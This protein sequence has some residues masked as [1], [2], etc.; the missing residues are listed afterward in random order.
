MK[1]DKKAVVLTLPEG[2]SDIIIFDDVL[3]GF[4]LRIRRAASGLVRRQWVC[5]YRNRRLLLGSAEVLSVEQAR[6]AAKKALATVA[7]GGDPQAEKADR[8]NQDQHTYRA[9]ADDYLAAKKVK[10]RPRT[11]VEAERY[12]T[13]DR[14]FGPLHS[15]PIDRVQRRDIA[16]RLETIERE[17]GTT[18]ACRARTNLSS[19]FAWGIASG[20]LE[21]NPT[22][23]A[24]QLRE[25]KPRERV[26]SD[27]ELVAV[28]QAC[29][30]DSDFSKI[31]KLLILTGAR[32]SEVGGMCWSEL[33]YGIWSLP[34][35]RSKNDRSHTLP[36]SPL[37]QS[38]IES[39]RHRN[40]R[41]LL[42]GH[43]AAAGFGQWDY[44]K[45][46]LDGRLGDKVGA[47]TLHDIR[48]TV[49]TRMCD[50]GVAP[51]IVETILNHQSGHKGGVAGIYNKSRY[52]HEVREALIKW[53]D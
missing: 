52:E 13:D 36:L 7:L 47:W 42:F 23:G 21:V 16:A 5:Q 43:T 51:H 37:A 6:A 25:P 15:T 44:S 24:G 33:S 19:M 45:G 27:A 53:A 29:S 35:E 40:D 20:R 12:L 9:V 17:C 18:T 32:R 14:Y 46:A 38:I 3:T 39:V 10:L 8:R 31:V 22:N 48:R 41:D 1:L 49:A 2:K 26:L 11:Y 50:L 34:A 4:G 30:D 28:W